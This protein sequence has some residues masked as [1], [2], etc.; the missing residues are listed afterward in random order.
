MTNRANDL[1]LIWASK[2]EATDPDLD[3]EH[4][5]FQPNKY[6][7]GWIVEKEP[8]QWQNFLYQI[9][10]QKLEIQAEE[11]FFEWES[12]IEYAPMA[13]ARNNGKIYINASGMVSQN[14]EPKDNPNFWFEVLGVTADDVNAARNFLQKT[15]DDHLAADNPHNDNIHDIGGYEKEEIDKFFNDENDPRTIRYHVKQTGKVH[16]ETPKQLGTL[17]VAGGT[18]TGDVAFAGGV[19]LGANGNT[20]VDATSVKLGNSAGAL[21]LNKDGSVKQAFANASDRYDVTTVANF[22][23]QQRAVNFLFALPVPRT[24]VDFRKSFSSMT[25]G[26]HRIESSVN[27]VMSYKGWQIADGFTIYNLDY[28]I[29]RTDLVE[30]YVNDVFRRV[31]VDSTVN[32]SGGADLKAIAQRIAPDATH[33]QRVVVYPQLNKYQK[34]N[35]L[36]KFASLHVQNDTS[37]NPGTAW[38]ISK[39]DNNLYEMPNATAPK[40][41]QY[42]GVFQMD[43]NG[44]RG[45]R[46]DNTA[47]WTTSDS[48]VVNISSVSSS[49]QA[50]V[51]IQKAGTAVLTVKWNGFVAQVTITAK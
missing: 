1:D 51:G 24:E 49:G 15:L 31:V 41:A 3:T 44:V 35:L 38:Y 42:I 2:G 5:I 47:V 21:Y 10:D 32:I 26:N 13:V 20:I 22:Q 27:P 8:H 50:I 17:P 40:G 43:A 23:Q 36:P 6:L 37:N 48:S 30:Y 4:P 12:D 14:V 29:A 9:T 25:I 39:I 45:G 18:F 16:S 33:I 11:Q 34:A 46:I 28:A 7:K 19:N